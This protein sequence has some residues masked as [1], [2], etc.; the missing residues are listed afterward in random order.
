[1]IRI[2][3][4]ATERRMEKAETA[5]AAKPGFSIP[6]AYLLLGLAGLVALGLSAGLWL[7]QAGRLRSLDSEIAKLQTRE[8]ELQAIKAQVDA[9]EAKKKTLTAKVDLIEKLR[10][11]QSSPVH[12]L[13]EISKALPDFVWLTNMEQT[14][15]AIK[16]TGESSSLTSIADFISNLQRTGWFPQV[17]LVSSDEQAAPSGGQSVVK[18]VLQANFVNPE[19]AAKA[20]AA[21]ASA[22]PPAPA[23]RKS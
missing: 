14:G 5:A 12:L 13:D 16:L 10:A 21:A 9:F 1:M 7:W 20:A 3:L 23:A 18:F 2:N 4:L 17:D 6:P 11:E 19:V 22:P 8:K 15:N